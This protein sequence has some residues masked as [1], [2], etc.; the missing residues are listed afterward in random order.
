[1]IEGKA[2]DWKLPQLSRKALIQGHCHHKSLLRFDDEKSTIHNLGLDFKLL[3]S[4]CCGMAGSFGFESDKYKVSVDIGERVLL[5]AVRDAERDTLIVADGFSCREQIAQLTN[6]QGLHLAEVIHMAQR[7][8]RASA[9]KYVE[10]SL[11]EPRQRVRR[12]SRIKALVAVA[13]IVSGTLWLTKLA[14]RS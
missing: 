4:G 5:P 6:R 14:K 7:D 10:S 13:A 9:G 1:L 8:G 3:P 2:S 12:R 11:L